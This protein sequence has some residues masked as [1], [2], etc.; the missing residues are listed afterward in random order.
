MTEGLAIELA[1]RKMEELGV[2]ENYLLRLRHFQIGSLS[3][4]ELDGE[5]HLYILVDPDNL[6]KVYSKAGVYN[7]L[8]EKL[9]E[10]TYLHRGKITVNNQGG[11]YLQVKFLQ[12]IPKNKEQ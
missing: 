12:V 4:L 11:G 3:K 5:N 1:K 7:V 8:D 6:T 9:N 10:M 2:G